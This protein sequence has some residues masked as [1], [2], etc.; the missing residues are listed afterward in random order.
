MTEHESVDIIKIVPGNR[1]FHSRTRCSACGKDAIESCCWQLS[2]HGL[3]ERTGGEKPKEAESSAHRCQ[4]GGSQD[5]S[6]ESEAGSSPIRIAIPSRK[7]TRKQPTEPKLLP[8]RVAGFVRIRMPSRETHRILTNPATTKKL[9]LPR[10]RFNRLIGFS[11]IR[12]QCPGRTQWSVSLR[13]FP[14]SGT[15]TREHQRH[16]LAPI[17][18]IPARH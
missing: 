7:V 9:R 13:P 1:H 15:R 16:R 4:P 5:K 12:Y 8:P 3:Q 11:G 2:L 6:K 17:L 10:A 14:A 18:A